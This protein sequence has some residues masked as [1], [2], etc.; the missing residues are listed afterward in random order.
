[1]FSDAGQAARQMILN[2]ERIGEDLGVRGPAAVF[3]AQVQ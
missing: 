1:L 3:I 2:D